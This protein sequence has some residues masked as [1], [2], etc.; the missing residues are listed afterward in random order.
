MTTHT[1]KLFAN[2]RSQAVRLPQEYRFEGK[3]VFIRREGDTVILSPRPVSWEG[4]F[5]NSE[6]IS[7]DF[8]NVR[9]D[10]VPQ[11]RESL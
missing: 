11:T 5:A 3:E 8:L 6:T 4:F 2:G 7:G 10:S 1:T 9:E